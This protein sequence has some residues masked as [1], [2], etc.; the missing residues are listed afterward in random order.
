MLVGIG[1]KIA[2]AADKLIWP[3]TYQTA[4]GTSGRAAAFVGD[5]QAAKE[6][7]K[8]RCTNAI[9]SRK[10]MQYILINS[11]WELGDILNVRCLTEF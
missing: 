1:V 5:A 9:V 8:Y 11:G 2:C 4:G 3:F 10:L 7:I 6:F